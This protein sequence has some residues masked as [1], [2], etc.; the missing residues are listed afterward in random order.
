[1]EEQKIEPVLTKKE[2]KAQKK[3]EKKE[4]KAQKKL[5]KKGKHPFRWLKVLVTLMLLMGIAG[6]VTISAFTLLNLKDYIVSQEEEKK[7]E[8]EK[9]EKEKETSEDFVTIAEQY[10]IKP[11][12]AISDAYKSNDT[13]LLDDKQ[14]ETLDMA[15]KA[16][17]EMGITDGMSDYEKEKAVYDWMTSSLQQDRG[18]LTVIPQSQED[19]DAPYGVLKYHNAVC[20]GYATTFRM[21]M[22]MLDVECMVVHNKEKWHTWNLIKL[23]GDW[24]IT[25]IYSDAGNGGYSHFNMTD[26][27]LG[28]MQNWDRSF[29]PSANSM[30]YNEGYKNKQTVDTVYDVGKAI[31]KAMDDKKA[32]VMVSF[33]EEINEQ[34]AQIVSAMVTAI[35]NSLMENSFKDYPYCLNTWNWIQDPVDNSYLLCVY[36]GGY[37]KDDIGGEQL[38]EEEQTKVQETVNLLM[39]DLVL[40]AMGVA[41]GQDGLSE[42]GYT[43]EG[44][45]EDGMIGEEI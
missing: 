11:T 39:E 2:I 27:M 14:K 6:S 5:E 44:F 42:D 24:Y 37:N 3:S 8:Q 29:F 43:E 32:S 26:I 25:D 34:N 12:T 23:D 21:F 41:E 1:M 31:R 35:D 30:K 33:K 19:C 17:E 15:K 9:L 36:M 7:K 45:S 18:A 22:Q 40:K 13:S 16:I 10:E 20:V 38:S 4:M 28:Q